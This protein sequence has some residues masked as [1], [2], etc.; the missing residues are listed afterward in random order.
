MSQNSDESPV[1]CP[2]CGTNSWFARG[3]DPRTPIL[4]RGEKLKECDSCGCR[5]KI[6]DPPPS[7]YPLFLR[8]GQTVQ[9]VPDVE[10]RT[11]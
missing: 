11:D 3:V 7:G 9:E 5:V 10:C 1:I 4:L 2:R 6:V 8:Q